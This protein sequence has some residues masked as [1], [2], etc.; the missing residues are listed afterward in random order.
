L[1]A[2]SG[3]TAVFRRWLCCYRLCCCSMETDCE[4][5]GDRV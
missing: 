1:K 3:N 5:E 4:T 2:I